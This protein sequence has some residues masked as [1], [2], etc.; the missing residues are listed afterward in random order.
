MNADADA[1][2]LL[3]AARAEQFNAMPECE[4]LR[5]HADMETGRDQPEPHQIVPRLISSLTTG[6]LR[7]ILTGDFSINLRRRAIFEFELRCIELGATHSVK[8]VDAVMGAVFS[9][10]RVRS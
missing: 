2:N 5:A 7:D 8:A 3:S 6:E 10:T 1:E 9:K 4:R